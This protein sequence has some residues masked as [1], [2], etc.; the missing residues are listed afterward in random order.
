MSNII[1]RIG[2]ITRKG[3]LLD[4]LSVV[5]VI[6]L[7][8]SLAVLTR[9]EQSLDKEGLAMLAAA[10]TADEPVQL[11]SGDGAGADQGRQS[12]RSN[13]QR[14]LSTSRDLAGRNYRPRLRGISSYLLVSHS[15]SEAACQVAHVR[16]R[17]TLIALARSGHGVAVVP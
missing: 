17:Q 12:K 16:P 1:G 7:V 15:W 14:T 11:A 13:Y 2:T 8:L 9:A 5:A 6:A 4:W 10:A 3:L